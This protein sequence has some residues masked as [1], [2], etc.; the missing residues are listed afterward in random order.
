MNRRLAFSA[1]FALVSVDAQSFLEVARSFR[2]Q[3]VD[4]GR[5]F[6]FDRFR[7]HA[8]D[9]PQQSARLPRIDVDC[10][11]QR[12]NAGAKER[13]VRINI[14]QPCDVFLIQQ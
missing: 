14:A 3:V 12:M 7:Q 8:L 13:F 6:V 9:R 2:V 5:A 11:C 4:D 1:A 10:R